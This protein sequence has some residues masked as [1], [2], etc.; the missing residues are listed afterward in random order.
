VR[1]SFPLFQ[2]GRV[3]P[4]LMTLQEREYFVARGLPVRRAVKFV[5][6]HRPAQKHIPTQ[7][8]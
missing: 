7:I 6:E 1:A 8:V 5:S 3:D 2:Y 4:K